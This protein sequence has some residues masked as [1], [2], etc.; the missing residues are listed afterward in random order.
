MMTI[1]EI[2]SLETLADDFGDIAEHAPWVADAATGKRPFADREAM[3]EA[4]T[5]AIMKA[6]KERQLELI[7]NHPDLAGKA[8]LTPDSQSEQ[9][10]AGLDT[11]TADE[12]DAFNQLNG[13]YKK[14]FGFPFIFA[15]RGAD[16]HQILASFRERVNNDA[17]DEFATALNMVCRIV[18]FRLE[19][20]VA[21]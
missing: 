21:P 16:K 2:N 19:D 18:R 15:V 11:L 13:A 9:K 17:K 20:R 10:G 4:F 3:I 5:D 8:K 7:N 1:A 6:N 14:R 12:F